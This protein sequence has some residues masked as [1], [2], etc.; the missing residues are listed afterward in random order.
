MNPGIPNF[1]SKKAL[2]V[3]LVDLGFVQLLDRLRGIQAFLLWYQ[4]I[5]ILESIFGII[6]I[7]MIAYSLDRM[8][9]SPR[10]IVLEYKAISL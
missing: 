9:V 5:C 6:A 8:L 3:L 10:T 7:M 4:S 1:Y 2:F